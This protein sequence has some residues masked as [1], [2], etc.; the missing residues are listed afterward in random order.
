M[1]TVTSASTGNNPTAWVG[2]LACYNEGRLIGD[3]FAAVDAD[4]V[5]TYDIHGTHT[6]ADTHDE[7]WIFDHESIPVRGE[8]SPPEATQW[9]IALTSVRDE[10]RQALNAWV[11]DG[12]YVSEGQSDLPSISDFEE[13]YCGQWDSFEDYAHHFADEIGLLA[14]VTAEIARYF[15]WNSWSRD[16]AYDYSICQADTGVYVFRALYAPAIPIESPRWR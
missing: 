13:R 10:E 4:T 12:D 14:G 2:C 9:G 15:D 11:R 8:M 16:L 1:V 6:R 5:T 3:W 7:L